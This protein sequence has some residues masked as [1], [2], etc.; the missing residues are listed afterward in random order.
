MKWQVVSLVVG[1]VCLVVGAA[2]VF[3]PA[4]VIVAGVAL[5]ATG[6]FVEGE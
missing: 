3:W 6:L 1:V 5:V 2:F 4:G